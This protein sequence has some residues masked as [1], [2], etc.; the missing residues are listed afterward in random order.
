MALNM[1]GQFLRSL[2]LL[3]DLL[4]ILA[5]K[6]FPV[7]TD[8]LF[9]TTSGVTALITVFVFLSALLLASFV[10]F[11]GVP[12]PGIQQRK[13]GRCSLCMHKTISVFFLPKKYT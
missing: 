7:L 8:K 9:L 5:L 11:L 12:S 1:K 4:N 10:P 3:S 6:L 13:V 2:F